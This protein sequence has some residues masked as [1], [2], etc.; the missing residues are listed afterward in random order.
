MGSPGIGPL[1]PP[2]A[3]AGGWWLLLLLLLHLQRVKIGHG[4]HHA[5]IRR[6][7][8]RKLSTPELPGHGFSTTGAA[9]VIGQRWSWSD[10]VKHGTLG[11]AP[12]GSGGTG[13]G[14]TGEQR[15]ATRVPE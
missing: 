5:E 3:K 8:V 10:T 1:I 15:R 9:Q 7:T 2:V 14:G 6:L 13:A 12:S 11:R 4:H